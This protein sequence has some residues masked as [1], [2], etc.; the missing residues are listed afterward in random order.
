MKSIKVL[1]IGVALFTLWSCS[2]NNDA[3]QQQVAMPPVQQQQMQT[4]PVDSAAQAQAQDPAQAQATA[5]NAQF[6]SKSWM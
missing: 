5:A 3:N 4:A 6:F 2:G 1:S